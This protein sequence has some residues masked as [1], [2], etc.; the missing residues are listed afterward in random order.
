[1]LSNDKARR[2]LD[3]Q[4]TVPLAEG[5]KQTAGWFRAHVK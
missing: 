3:W 5:L 2:L 1:V 4:P